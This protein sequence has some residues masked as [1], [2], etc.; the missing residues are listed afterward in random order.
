MDN[1]VDVASMDGEAGPS[2]RPTISDLTGDH[3]LA[4]LARANWLTSS[5][6]KVLP[7]LVEQEIWTHVEDEGFPY[8]SF[9]LLEQLQA[10]ERYLWPGYSE[11]ASNHHV[12]L[13][14]LLVN[15]KRHQQLPVWSL[16]AE[17]PDDFSTFFR[18]LLH[19]S[20]DRSLPTNIR[21]HLLTV[22]VG[23]FQSLDNGLVRKECA[24][25]VSIGTWHH[26]HSDAVRE[27]HLSKSTQLQKAW[28]AAGK[29][30]ENADA[31]GQAR[32]RFERS[33]LYT[34]LIEFL[35]KLYDAGAGADQKQEDLFY[36]ERF[37]ELL[38]DLQSQLPTRRY[39]NTLLQD[40]NLLPVIHLS[41]LYDEAGDAGGLLRDMT[42][43]LFHYTYFPIDDQTAR[44]LSRQEYEEA[45]NRQIARLQ[46]VALRVHPEKLKILILANYG[47]LAQRGGVDK[48]PPRNTGC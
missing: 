43:L 17:R 5:P 24:P 47:A 21:T 37:L 29:K 33:W 38:C 7:K 42:Q 48:S 13:L 35:D 25:L 22:L 9:V 32:L 41:P 45:H 12:L 3:H 16:F 20:I 18:R 10:L 4:K 34:S 15:V 27:R 1:S 23:A 19:L 39:V 14:A 6:Q 46:K 26:L 2:G 28:R 44:Q 11:D 30:Y 36:C 31:A 40:L 8:F